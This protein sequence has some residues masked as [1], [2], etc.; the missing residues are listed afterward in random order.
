MLSTAHASEQ[1]N[2]ELQSLPSLIQKAYCYCAQ[3][4]PC[5]CRL[6]S[7]DSLCESHRKHASFCSEDIALN[8]VTVRAKKISVPRKNEA[9]ICH[10]LAA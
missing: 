8:K 10:R 1:Q 9:D 4:V 3:Q 5:S 6:Q 7:E 2:V